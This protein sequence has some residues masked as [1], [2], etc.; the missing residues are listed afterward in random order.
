MEFLRE[1]LQSFRAEPW[2]DWVLAIGLAALF[3][4][5]LSL[6]RRLVV[7][8]LR[9]FAARTE[10]RLDDLALAVLERIRAWFFILI[11]I[12]LSLDALDFSFRNAKIFKAIFTLGFAAQ[13]LMLGNHVIEFALQGFLK[14]RINGENQDALMATAI[15]TLRFICQLI[16]VG[17]IIVL[18]LDH[19]G[20]DVTAIVTGLGVG[21]IAIAL[22]VQNVLGDLFASLSIVIDKPF[23]VGDVISVSEG[24]TGTV[25]KIG[26]KTTRIRSLSGE[27]LIFSNAQLLGSAIRNFKRM[28]ER[29]IV[30]RLGVTYQ[31]PAEKLKSIP[32]ILREIIEHVGETRV[33]RIHFQAFGDSALIFEVVYF[34]LSPE[35]LDYAN[36]EEQINFQIFERFEKEGI[37]FAYPTQTIFHSVMKS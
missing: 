27:Q 17:L 9:L 7:S 21:G 35:Y 25:E 11:A 6:A 32:G 26:L 3:Y 15:P 30:F 14:R 8:K 33:D 18:A 5:V 1:S 2:F 31:T 10:T 22:A 16:F 12:F 34:I 19:L 29:R 20:F 37:Q 24:M 23:V 4:F 13:F 28:Q 36:R